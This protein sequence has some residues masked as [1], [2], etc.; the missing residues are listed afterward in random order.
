M[1]ESQ[2]RLIKGGMP[3]T[4]LIRHTF[5]LNV[6]AR[7]CEEEVELDDSMLYHLKEVLEKKLKFYKE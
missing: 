6:D 1:V 2:L 4:C 5:I 7:W 3:K